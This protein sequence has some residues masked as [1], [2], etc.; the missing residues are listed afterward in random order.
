M[1]TRIPQEIIAAE[2]A[3]DHDDF[4]NDQPLNFQFYYGTVGNPQIIDTIYLEDGNDPLKLILEVFNE[5]FQSIQFKKAGAVGRL[6]TVQAVGTQAASRTNCHFYIRWAKDLELIPG[7]IKIEEEAEW[8]VNYDEDTRFFS[9]YFLHK[10]GI[11]LGSQGS[12]NDKIRLTFND[13]VANNRA[14]KSSNVELLYGGESPLVY[15]GEGNSGELITEQISSQKAVYVTNYP[16]KQQIPLQVRLLGSNTILN[17]GITENTLKLKVINSPLSNNTRPIL[18]LDSTSKFI[19][20]F[21]KGDNPEALVTDDQLKKVKISATPEAWEPTLPT[22]NSTEWKFTAKNIKKLAKDEGIELSITEL[23]TSSASGLAYLYIDYQ[24]IGSYPD[25][26]LV[27]AIEKTP[28]LYSGQQVGIGTTTPKKELHVVGD[29]V[30]GKDENN[31]KFI[32]HSRKDNNGDYL[33]ITNDSSDGSLGGWPGITLK[34]DG[35]VGI[36]K[37]D[38]QAPLDVEGK[39]RM[40]SHHLIYVGLETGNES[41]T[42]GIYANT[43]RKNSGSWIECPGAVLPSTLTKNLTLGGNGIDFYHNS[44]ASQEGTLGMRLTSEGKLGIGTT[45]PK[46]ELH[47][48]GDLVL[49]KDENNNKFIFHSRK[50]NNGDYLQITYDKPDGSLESWQGITLNRDGNVGIGK[51]DPQAPLDVN[52][53]IRMY[54]DNLIYVGLETGHESHTIGIYAN[55]DRKNSRSWIECPGA[56]LPSSLPKNLTLGG[57][58]IDFYHNST[59]SQEGTLG[60]TLTSEGKLGIGTTNPA[61]K[62]HINDG[63]LTMTDADNKFTIQVLKTRVYFSLSNSGYGRNRFISWDGDGNWDDVSSDLRLKTDIDPEKNILNRL[64]ELEVKNYRWKDEPEK[65]TKMIGFVA[66]DVKPWFP[67]LVGEAKNSEND[68]TTLTL[69]SGAFGILAVGGLKELKLEKDAEIAELKALL[70]DEI[71]EL[72]GQIQQSKG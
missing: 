72:K 41:H 47:V 58:G 8:Q 12:S 22:G 45:D 50:D 69:K 16:S 59:A 64:M 66:Q 14:V 71:A 13:F 67:S 52:G 60:M 68:E 49:G 31:K 70:H 44:T 61:S 38:P 17:D 20:S 7:N 36:G 6:S 63:M 23:V 9:I 5:S 56:V 24:N 11:V 27:V 48:V 18:R 1:V 33:Q 37:T 51:T 26:R 30:L 43:D 42:I 39:I 40:H 65:L 3:L 53:K 35:N 4:V 46:K 15:R 54:S 21:V 34:R 19:V 25:G 2:R 55:T 28:L 62:L 29:L 10:N 57:N 32:F